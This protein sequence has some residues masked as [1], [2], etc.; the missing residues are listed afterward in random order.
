MQMIPV[1]SSLLKT[2]GFDDEK[3]E[4]RVAFHTGGSYV[5]RGVPRSVFDALLNDH[6]AGHF[7]L[8]NIKAKYE[9]VK[10]SSNADH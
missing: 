1:A 3:E 4:L 6:S 2:V 10:E 8:V 7:F 9:C 5:Y